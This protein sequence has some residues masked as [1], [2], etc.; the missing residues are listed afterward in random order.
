[1]PGRL[2]ASGVMRSAANG[3][4]ALERRGFA[5]SLP[6]VPQPRR[7]QTGPVVSADAP[8]VVW[9]IDFQFERLHGG[10][11]FKIAYAVD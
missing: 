8:S 11:R 2:Y 3:L 7:D 9:A 6:A 5:G 10:R 4:I 1:M